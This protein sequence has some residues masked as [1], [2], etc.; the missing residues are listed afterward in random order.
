[1]AWF[2]SKRQI[3]PLGWNA[4]PVRP[5]VICDYRFTQEQLIDQDGVKQDPDEPQTLAYK[6][7]DGKWKLRPMPEADHMCY[8]KDCANLTF[9]DCYGECGGGYLGIVRP[10]DFCSHGCRREGVDG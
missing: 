1:M 8:C 5:N 3:R 4:Q 6:G 10:D 2:I 7:S 9:S